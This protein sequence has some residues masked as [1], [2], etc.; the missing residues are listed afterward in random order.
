LIAEKTFTKSSFIYLDKP[1]DD[2]QRRMPQIEKLT[3]ATGWFPSVD[4][5][6]GLN[7]TIS[8]FKAELQVA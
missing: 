4:L 8:Y 2:P 1:Q 7:Q 3:Q 6:D 5:A